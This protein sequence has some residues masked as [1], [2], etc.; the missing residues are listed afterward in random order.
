M[1]FSDEWCNEADYF[2][3]QVGDD[4]SHGRSHK[5]YR[6]IPHNTLDWVKKRGLGAVRVFGRSFND[7][8]IES[9]EY[10]YIYCVLNGNAAK[11]AD[12]HGQSD[13]AIETALKMTFP[14]FK[15][16]WFSYDPNYC[17]TTAKTRGGG[18]RLVLDL[19]AIGDWIGK[20]NAFCFP[21]NAEGWGIFWSGDT[22]PF[23]IAV[24]DVDEGEDC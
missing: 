20:Y 16:L 17:G 6:W 1:R 23:K 4:L 9:H 2:M 18:V 13:A 3:V 22:I 5:G 10:A 24:L 19:D 15:S 14:K 8:F 7:I 21:D 12:A 11:Y